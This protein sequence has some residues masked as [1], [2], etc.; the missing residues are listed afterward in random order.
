MQPDEFFRRDRLGTIAG[1]DQGVEMMVGGDDEVRAGGDGAI[2]ESVVVGIAG[3]R[4]KPVA[5]TDV[6][7][8]A[9][10]RIYQRN[11]REKSRND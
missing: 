7:D 9:V 5:R 1:A 4:M 2:C 11:S 8:A 6:A 10:Q 3:D